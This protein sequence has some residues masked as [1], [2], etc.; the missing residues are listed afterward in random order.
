[1][2]KIEIQINKEKPLETHRFGAKV[3]RRSDEERPW[4]LTFGANLPREGPVEQVLGNSEVK[5]GRRK[6]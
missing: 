6:K 1:M 4:Q 2:P 5:R 3:V